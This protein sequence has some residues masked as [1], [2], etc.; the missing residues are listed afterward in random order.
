MERIPVFCKHY[1]TETEENDDSIPT[2]G[3]VFGDRSIVLESHQT[4]LRKLVGKFCSTTVWGGIME[5]DETV[6]KDA[7]SADINTVQAFDPEDKESVVAFVGGIDGSQPLFDFII[8]FD[9]QFDSKGLETAE[10]FSPIINNLKEK[11]EKDDI[12]VTPYAD[13]YASIKYGSYLVQ[14]RANRN[15]AYTLGCPLSNVNDTEIYIYSA[16]QLQSI[17]DLSG[18]MVGYADFSMATRLQSLKVG[19][20]TDSYSNGNLTELY[21]GN[22][23]LLRTLDVRNCPNLKQAVDVSGCTNIEYLY[24]EGTAVTGVQLPNGGILKTLHLPATVTNLTIRNQ[25]AIT[26]FSIGGYDNISTLRLENVSEVFDKKA[27]LESI[28]A[29]A[30][31]RITGLNWTADS[32]QDI[33][34]FYDRLDTMRGLDENGNNVEKAQIV[35]SVFVSELY[36]TELEE[37]LERYPNIKVMYTTLTS[38]L[39]YYDDSGENLFYT[40]TITNGGDG[41]FTGYPYK[42]STVEN[43]FSFVGWSREPGGTV[44]SECRKAVLTDRNVYAVYKADIRK[45]TVW[46]YNESTLLQTVTTGLSTGFQQLWH[47]RGW[48]CRHVCG[49]EKPQLVLLQQRKRPEGCDHRVRLR[50]H[51]ALRFPGC[52]LPDAD[53]ALCGHL[54]TQRQEEAPVVGRQGYYAGLY[55]KSR[56]DG[57]DSPPLVCKQ[58]LSGKLDVCANG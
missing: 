30:R 37:M 15:V 21:L 29:G 19:D 55:S 6:L 52:G 28:P 45:Y 17:G 51:G 44:D 39:R 50:Y 9:S 38:Y 35:G 25:K 40:E 18:L 33:L 57:S 31:V 26:D 53:Q 41:K 20:A 23:T 27:I 43:T 58:V 54:Q 11:R 10:R 36:G 4:D 3:G 2:I 24:F 13:I 5:T 34:T 32:A 46:F 22:N 1:D 49:G 14:Q 12:T 56:R 48:T 42:D 47:R 7:I 16:S 8:Q